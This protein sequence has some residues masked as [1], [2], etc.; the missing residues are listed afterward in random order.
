VIQLDSTLRVESM[1]TDHVAHDFVKQ[2]EEDF[3]ASV[4]ADLGRE[5]DAGRLREGLHLDLVARLTTSVVEGLQL[6][7]LSDPSVDMPAHMAA[8]MDLLRKPTDDG[9]DSQ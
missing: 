3:L 7:W 5:A 2:R 6:A 4:R 8:F 1:H 9:T